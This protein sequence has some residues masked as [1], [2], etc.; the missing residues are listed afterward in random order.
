MFDVSDDPQTF[1]EAIEFFRQ[2]LGMSAKDYY[3]LEEA[4]RA[5]AFTVSGVADLDL[6]QQ[7][8]SSLDK[9]IEKGKGF[10]VFQRE[11]KESLEA[12][13]GRSDKVT[14]W[15]IE[16]IYRTNVQSAYAAGRFQQQTDPDVLELRPYFLYDAV[17]DDGTSSICRGFNGTLLP[18]DDPFWKT[19]YPPN[20]FSCRSAV[21][22]LKP[23]QAERL[24]G[25]TKRP[26]TSPQDGFDV[27]PGTPYKPDMKKYDPELQKVAKKKL[28]PKK[29]KKK[30]GDA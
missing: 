6:I 1:D 7:V 13:W 26:T 3:A 15:R 10:A 8:F 18:A 30:K 12:A 14:G 22:T 19:S 25:V 27:P 16:N 2:K 20:H 4:L 28:K 29:S 21:R 24:G 23:K 9:A 5:Q 17:I 11:V